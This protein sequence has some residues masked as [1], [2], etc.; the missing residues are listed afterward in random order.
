MM[1]V[2][3]MTKLLRCVTISKGK[4]VKARVLGSS[5]LN[6]ALDDIESGFDEVFDYYITHDYYLRAF[7]DAYLA[8]MP[9][10]FYRLVEVAKNE[11]GTK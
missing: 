3:V 9:A 11:L 6:L 8:V 4:T 2:Q 1:L 7:P 5:E 10:K